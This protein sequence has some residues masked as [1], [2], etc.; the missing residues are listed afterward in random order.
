MTALQQ[1]WIMD[2]YDSQMQLPYKQT[3]SFSHKE[4]QVFITILYILPM[5]FSKIQH[6]LANAYRVRV[7]AVVRLN[8]AHNFLIQ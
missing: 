1:I 3:L 2:P 5:P 6:K 4:G 7:Y 8:R